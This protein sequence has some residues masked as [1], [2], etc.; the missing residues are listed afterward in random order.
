MQISFFLTPP[1]QPVFVLRAIFSAL[2]IFAPTCFSPQMPDQ[3]FDEILGVELCF[4][5]Q[6]RLS[7]P[8][9]YLQNDLSGSE[10]HSSLFSALEF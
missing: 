6:N 10:S 1:S 7:L 4:L 8:K 3:L 2:L 9:P 5:A